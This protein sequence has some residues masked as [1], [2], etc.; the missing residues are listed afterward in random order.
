MGFRAFFILIVLASFTF[1]GCVGQRIMNT[2]ANDIAKESN[3][4]PI[5]I[6]TSTF[7]LKGYFRFNNAKAP[8]TIYIEGDGLAYLQRNI[9]SS[10]PTPRNPLGLRLAAMDLGENVLY[11]ARPCQYVSFKVER[12][13]KVPYWTHKR[14][15]NEVILAVNE[16]IEKMVS[17]A[18]VDRIHLVGYSGGGAVAALVA[19][20][21]IDVASLRTLAGYMDH[22]LLNRKVGVS[23]LKGSLDPIKQAPNLKRIPQIHYSGKKDKVIPK[24]V[25]KNFARAVGNK[26]CTFVRL[27]N[28]TH[29]KGWEKVWGKGW[30]KI[31]ACR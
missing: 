14:F 6:P 19:A 28:A 11:L 3:L 22:V 7:H 20:R 27:V 12:L 2:L 1:S 4:K 17:R 8:L 16:A 23:P 29:F 24:W 26:N 15:S 18:G 30:S 13:C 31:P 10:N 9:P 25:A 5:L 21:R